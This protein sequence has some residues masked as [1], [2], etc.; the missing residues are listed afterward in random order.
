MRNNKLINL[1]GQRFG[2][3]VVTERGMNSSSGQARWI[4]LC[5]CGGHAE[6]TGNNLRRGRTTSCGCDW[7]RSTIEDLTGQ[8]FGRLTVIERAADRDGR[9]RWACK[10]ECEQT[11][12]ASTNL[13]RTGLTRKCRT[14]CAE[15]TGRRPWPRRPQYW[16]GEDGSIAGPRGQ[17][18]TPFLADN[19]YYQVASRGWCEHLHVIVCETFHGPR[20]PGMQVAH[21]NGDST[22][23]RASNLS[24]KTPLG[25]AADRIRHGTQVQGERVASAKLTETDVRQIRALA[26]S[27]VSQYTIADQFNITRPNVGY[28]VR[29]QT[30]AHVS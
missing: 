10:C 8:Q 22:D 4:C 29:R 13:L 3:L 16:V 17:L 1:T 23:C 15:M 25:N 26:A 20:P 19:G 7:N 5:D 14:A 24:W 18:L 21:E 9:R 28:I 27:G 11:I 12:T 2:R 6:T 30:W